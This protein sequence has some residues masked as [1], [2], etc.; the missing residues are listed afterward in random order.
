MLPLAL[1]VSRPIPGQP[2]FAE[3]LRPAKDRAAQWQAIVA[4]RA[5]HRLCYVFENPADF[6]AFSLEVPYAREGN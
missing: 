4:A 1:F 6:L 2:M 3:T 5:N